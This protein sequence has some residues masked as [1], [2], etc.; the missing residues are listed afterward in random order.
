[1]AVRRVPLSEAMDLPLAFEVTEDLLESGRTSLEATLREHGWKGHS[2]PIA[3]SSE[4]GVV[5]G[6][7]GSLKMNFQ[8]EGDGNVNT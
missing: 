3:A 2:Q 8:K 1:M 4:A 7:D 5:C 6:A